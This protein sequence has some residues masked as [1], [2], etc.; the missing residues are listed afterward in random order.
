LNKFLDKF[1]PEFIEEKNRQQSEENKAVHEEFISNLRIGKCFM[2]GLDMNAFIESKPCFH[3][4]T[5]PSG[6]KKKNFE[7]Y[8]QNS[9]GFFQLDSYFRWLANSEVF[10][11]NINDL[12]DETSSMSYLETTYK[13]KNIE[14]AFSIG[15]TD[16]EGHSA[17]KVGNNPHYHIQM[18]VNDNIF[19]KFND[20]HI[21][22][23]DQDLFVI[24]L[25]EQASDKVIKRSSLGAGMSVIED[26]EFMQE[27]D[28]HMVRSDNNSAAPF[29]RQTIIIAPE[30]ESI[31]D[32]IINKAYEESKRTNV[33]VSKIIQNYLP[34]A[35][36]I[37]QI[38]H[39]EAVPP[40]TKRSGKK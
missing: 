37:V 18:K 29:N 4:F 26:T 11:T 23:S 2:Y 24:E 35:E 16:L 30:G 5:Y 39:G 36:V 40:M 3:W 31:T 33:P 19:L 25:Q 17:A 7:K 1:T 32:E 9:I 34:G 6:I 22:F 8:L 21:P 12:K 14:W 10:M 13:Y 20:F 38:T 28:D 27:L 15:K